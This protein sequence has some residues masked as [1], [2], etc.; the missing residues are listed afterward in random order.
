MLFNSNVDFMETLNKSELFISICYFQFIF[1][2][3][4]LVPFIPAV[5]E[6]L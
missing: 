3:S 6:L 1:S 2:V 4:S 5:Q